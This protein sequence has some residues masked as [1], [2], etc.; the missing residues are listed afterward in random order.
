MTSPMCLRD[1]SAPDSAW[2][3]DKVCILGLSGLQGYLAS[4]NDRNNKIAQIGFKPEYSKVLC[5]FFSFE[6]SV[7]F[8]A[9][10]AVLFYQR[11]PSSPEK[12]EGNVRVPANLHRFDH[13]AR[14]T[15][16]W[17]PKVHRMKGKTQQRHCE[18]TFGV[19]VCGCMY[20]FVCVCMCQNSESK[21]FW[22]SCATKKQ[23]NCSKYLNKIARLQARV[24]IS[25]M[26]QNFRDLLFI[27][28]KSVFSNNYVKF[29]NFMPHGWERRSFLNSRNRVQWWNE[30]TPLKPAAPKDSN[31]TWVLG[32]FNKFT[33]L[34]RY[35]CTR[36]GVLIYEYLLLEIL[37]NS[38]NAPGPTI[39]VFTF[40]LSC[41]HSAPSTWAK[42]LFFCA[43]S[44]SVVPFHHRTLLSRSGENKR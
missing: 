18:R 8:A 16:R 38:I 40:L 1:S 25:H 19:C 27:C 37:A 33:Q 17:A 4:K 24:Q 7:I 2:A 36:N 14:T 42:G 21:T 13:L 35:K 11:R 9:W 22:K 28:G 23:K 39:D 31:T 15:S 20:V 44:R 29:E 5:F 30:A 3:V 26:T 41:F 12:R 6:M 34:A 43:C 32:N 10:E